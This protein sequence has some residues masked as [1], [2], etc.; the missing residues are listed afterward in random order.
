MKF[1]SGDD[2]NPIRFLTAIGGDGAPGSGTAFL[3]SFL[4]VSIG[5]ASSPENFPLFGANTSETS[6]ACRKFVL[7][8]VSNARFLESQTFET[9][10]SNNERIE[11]QFKLAELP[12]DVKMLCF[13]AGKLS[14]ASY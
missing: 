8:L 7:E 12:N 3:L 2:S 10:I 5:I 14:N 13:L 4:N 11:F 9:Q 1:N 6:H